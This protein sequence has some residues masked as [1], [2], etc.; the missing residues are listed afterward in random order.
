MEMTGQL[1]ALATVS[2]GKDSLIPTKQEAWWA[3]ELIRMFW[4][5]D[6]SP[7]SARNRIVIPELSSP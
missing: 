2:P 4:S 5:T 1:H 7:V 6:K 3:P